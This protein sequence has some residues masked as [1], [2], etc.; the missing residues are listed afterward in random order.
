LSPAFLVNRFLTLLLRTSEHPKAVTRPSAARQLARLLPLLPVCIAISGCTLYPEAKPTLS[1]TTSAEQTQRLFW[2]EV[3]EQKWL[4]VQGQ[5]LP[6]VTWRNGK[7]VLER[8]AVVPYLKQ[9]QVRDFLITNVVV[10]SNA[11]DMTV[12]YDLQ[13]TTAASAQPINFHAVS[14][15]QQVPPPPDN[16][17]KK[18]KKE[19]D[20]SAPYLLIVEDLVPDT[21]S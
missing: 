19:A 10:K 7:S 12:L 4:L 6:N 15:W 2:Q 17:S 16:A 14:V 8:D 11:E 18:E 5:L 9:Q 20:K 1:N 3:K 21:I 13:I